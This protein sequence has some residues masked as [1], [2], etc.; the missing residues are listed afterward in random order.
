MK[1]VIVTSNT[2]GRYRIV[3]ADDAMRALLEANGGGY[4]E[5]QTAATMEQMQQLR[6][7]ETISR[8]GCTWKN[9]DVSEAAALAAEA[10]ADAQAR[11]FFDD[12][13]EVVHI[14]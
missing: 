12:H 2:T 10:E 11:R 5:Q 14:K 4:T 6:A 1:K 7:G 8:G 13:V 9:Y 3:S